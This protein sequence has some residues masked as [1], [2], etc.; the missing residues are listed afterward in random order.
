MRTVEMRPRH[1]VAAI[2]GE[3][4]LR[5]LEGPTGDT[6]PGWSKLRVP[7]DEDKDPFPIVAAF[8]RP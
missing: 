8:L 1:Y 4:V 6:V 3:F 7:K 2:Q 5:R